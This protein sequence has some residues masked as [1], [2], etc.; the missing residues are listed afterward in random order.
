MAS[1][2]DS[3]PLRPLFGGRPRNRCGRGCS[4]S[5]ALFGSNRAQPGMKR[6]NTILRESVPHTAVLLALLTAGGSLAWASKH[7]LA[8]E[9]RT[10]AAAQM[11]LRQ[12]ADQLA[13]A[14]QEEREGRDYVELYRRLKDLRIL[15]EERR[16][17]W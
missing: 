8:K 16:L 2:C 14:T 12:K 3:A 17:E 15:G 6:F 9:H 5:A 7:W 11:E 10:L 1:H 4:G 13:R